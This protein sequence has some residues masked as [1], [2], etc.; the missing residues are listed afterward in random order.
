MR[1][2]GR[3][4]VPLRRP[5][6]FLAPLAVSSRTYARKYTDL[7]ELL[8]QRCERAAGGLIAIGPPACRLP[9]LVVG[10][11]LWP[12][13]GGHFSVLTMLASGVAAAATATAVRFR[14]LGC[15]RREMAWRHAGS[16][17][18]V[19]TGGR[20]TGWFGACRSVPPRG[21]G[22]KSERES[23]GG[24]AVGLIQFLME[25]APA[26][27]AWLGLACL[28]S[29]KRDRWQEMVWV[30]SRVVPPYQL[31]LI[32]KHTVRPCSFSPFLAA[33]VLLLFQDR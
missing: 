31:P 25:K 33:K 8:V 9:C 6:V 3:P 19:I 26:Y 22:G 12:L 14:R 2:R 20:G 30:S 17:F 4:A 23:R 18:S 32:V 7:I 13:A 5:H 28:A 29:Y 10:S 24:C 21:P 15:A 27:P 11:W 1:L 16:H